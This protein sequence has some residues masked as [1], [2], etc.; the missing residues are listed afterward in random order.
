M[1]FEALSKEDQKYVEDRHRR[2]LIKL[3]ESRKHMK[4]WE[5]EHARKRLQELKHDR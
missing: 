3:Y 5:G 4:G 2:Q 1:P